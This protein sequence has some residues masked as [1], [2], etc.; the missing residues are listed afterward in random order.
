MGVALQ[1][2]KIQVLEHAKQQK[3]AGNK[4][5]QA[6]DF[7]EAAAA[8]KTA[9]E[10]LEGWEQE[11][12]AEALA[13]RLVSEAQVPKS[14]TAGSETV[15]PK[16]SKDATQEERR[17]L[18][19]S[20]HLNLTQVELKRGVD[21]SAAINHATQALQF[22]PDNAKALYRRS[23]ARLRMGLDLEGARNDALNAA[24]LNPQSAEVRELLQ[25]VTAQLQ[26]AKAKDKDTFAGMFEKMS[27]PRVPDPIHFGEP[28]TVR[29]A[30]DNEG[31]PGL[32]LS[33]RKGEGFHV[34]AI[35]N[36][37]GQ[38]ELKGGDVILAIEGTALDSEVE[39]Q[40][41]KIF[42]EKSPLKEGMELLVKS[43]LDPPPISP[44]K[45][46]GYAASEVP[47]APSGASQ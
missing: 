25:E 37:P 41:M 47:A 7:V 20:C 22:D 36:T 29:L 31:E 14:T 45:S 28:H 33:W 17:Q 12:R 18:L 2:G 11:D 15:E 26:Q 19:L 3:E 1:E 46:G 10:A 42:K 38:P 34:D 40:V 32:A 4:A 8:Y 44:T 6:L 30:V 5:F 21:L 13:N 27:D 24:R 9:I 16:E 23:Q 35:R 43:R 39:S